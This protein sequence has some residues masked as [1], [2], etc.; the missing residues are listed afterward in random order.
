MIL[1][2]CVEKLYVPISASVDITLS[3]N[4]D[5]TLSGTF[6]F[7]GHLN[8]DTIRVTDGKFTNVKYNQGYQ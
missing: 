2:S 3:D 1:F 8:G 4:V 5:M 7:Y 6:E